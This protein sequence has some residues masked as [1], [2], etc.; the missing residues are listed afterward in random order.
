MKS[1]S[2]WSAPPLGTSYLGTEGD[3]LQDALYGEHG[4]EDEVQVAQDVHEL[5]RG[6]LELK[7]LKQW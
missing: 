6:S 3:Q 1:R 2:G 5:E 4:G 7:Q